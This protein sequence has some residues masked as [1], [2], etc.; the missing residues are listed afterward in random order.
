MTAAQA[1]GPVGSLGQQNSRVL[2]PVL[3]EVRLQRWLIGIGSGGA[4][5]QSLSHGSGTLWLSSLL[6]AK[7]PVSPLSFAGEAGVQLMF[8][9]LVSGRIRRVWGRQVGRSWF[10][11]PF[12]LS[13][14]I[15]MGRVCLPVC[16]SMERIFEVINHFCMCRVRTYWETALK[17]ESMTENLILHDLL[18]LP[19]CLQILPV[20]FN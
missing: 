8:S 11:V 10:C 6:L 3:P 20:S 1:P 5:G 13:F 16:A 9:D 17:Y 14:L 15:L 4:G 7:A 12:T 2:V 19:E 18:P